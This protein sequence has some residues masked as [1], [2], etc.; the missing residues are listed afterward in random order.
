[1]CPAFKAFKDRFTLLL[2]ANLM[3]DCKLKP[4]L[5]YHA[6]NPH[7]LKGYEKKSLPVHWYSNSS[8]WMMGHIFQEYSKT[9]LL[10]ELKEYCLSKGLP[11]K[12]L[13]VLDNAPAHPQMLQ[14]LHS[15]IKFAFL[16]PNTTSLLQLM[17]QGVICMFKTHFL[18]K[19]WRSLSL[20]CD[21]SLDEL[22]KATQA[23]EN[24]V[25]LQKDVVRQHWKSYTVRDALWQVRDAWR[26]VT[27]CC[28]G[29]LWKKLCLHLAVDFEGFDHSEGFSKERLKC[30]EVKEDDLELLL[31]SIGK[32]LTTESLKI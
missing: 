28:I 1:M 15:N 24:P 29:G 32:E 3:G 19:S 27:E 20:K 9:Q 2:R 6:E 13:M 14:D 5:V 21:V 31:E 23:P 10:G 18:K 4:V 12:I 26:E 30:L 11:F 25:E 17:D 22:E 16:L 7:A 8:G